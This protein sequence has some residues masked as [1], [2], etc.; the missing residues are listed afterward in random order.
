M[1]HGTPSQVASCRIARFTVWLCPALLYILLDQLGYLKPNHAPKDVF[2]YVKSFT[3]T[4][5]GI[6]PKQ[7]RDHVSQLNEYLHKVYKERKYLRSFTIWYAWPGQRRNVN[8]CW[9]SSLGG[10][11]GAVSKIITPSPYLSIYELLTLHSK[12]TDFQ[13][14]GPR[15]ASSGKPLFH[16]FRRHANAS[17]HIRAQELKTLT[18]H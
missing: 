13:D 9:T 5:H 2:T 3:T 6:L 18:R 4:C 1:L 16:R 7:R 11:S 12:T 8:P 14:S 17:M 15:P 10:H